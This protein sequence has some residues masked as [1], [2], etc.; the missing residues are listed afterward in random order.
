MIF[1]NDVYAVS[2]A[3]VFAAVDM[4]IGSTRWTL[5][6][7]AI[8]TPWPVG[9][10]VYVVDQAGEVI[11]VARESGQV[12]WIRDLN[13][14]LTK[15]RRSLWS[16][17]ILASNRLITISDKGEAIALNPKTGATLGTLKIGSDTMIGPIAIN[18]M[19]YVVTQ[20]AQ[21][22]AIR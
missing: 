8:T 10:V 1:R 7:S 4:R 6:I 21:L 12:Y 13:K 9:D 20:T 2:H 14:G 22:V 11:C 19:I 15:K 3:N 18:G 17:P 5:P 16:S